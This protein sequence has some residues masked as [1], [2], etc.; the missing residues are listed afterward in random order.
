MISVNG[1]KMPL[2]LLLLIILYKSFESDQEMTRKNGKVVATRM[3][4]PIL[5]QWKRSNNPGTRE[6]ETLDPGEFVFVGRED[7]SCSPCVLDPAPQPKQNN[8]MVC[9]NRKIEMN[10]A[11]PGLFFCT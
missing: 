4:M 11:H 10:V 1:V 6:G 8:H 3:V 5:W 9:E 7:Y 2:F